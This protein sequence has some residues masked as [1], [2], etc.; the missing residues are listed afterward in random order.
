[1]IDV[2]NKYIVL[3]GSLM[4]ATE[5]K[6]TQAHMNFLKDLYASRAQI[7]CTDITG[8]I[9]EGVING[10]DDETISLRDEYGQIYVFFKRNLISFSPLDSEG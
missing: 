5:R 2:R 9:T 4:H 7:M 3:V 1:M 8:D 10:Y 6:T